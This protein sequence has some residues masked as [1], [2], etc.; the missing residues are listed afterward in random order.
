MGRRHAHQVCLPAAGPA[1]G[2]RLPRQ[3]HPDPQPEH[4]GPA[5]QDRRDGQGRAGR[6]LHAEGGPRRRLVLP[7]PPRQRPR[8]RLGRRQRPRLG[9]RH[10]QVLR[11][12]LGAQRLGQ[13]HRQAVGGPEVL[14][15]LRPCLEALP[16][17]QGRRAVRLVLLRQDRLHLGRQRPAEP[18]HRQEVAGRHER[19]ALHLP[20]GRAPLGHRLRRQG[21]QDLGLRDR[22]ADPTYVHPRRGH[23]RGLHRR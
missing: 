8:H 16:P 9:H 3:G 21:G 1:R 23:W 12:V 17:G 5:A 13:G 22:R 4:G 11:H 6:Q 2:R 10:G 14:G 15:E 19:S 18:Q 7:A 20:S